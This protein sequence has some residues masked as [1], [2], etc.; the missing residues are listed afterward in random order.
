LQIENILQVLALA[1]QIPAS[2]VV[3]P[4]LEPVV[5]F[6]MGSRGEL[7]QVEAAVAVRHT[8][9]PPP[10]QH[11]MLVEDQQ[12]EDH[13]QITQPHQLQ[14]FIIHLQMLELDIAIWAAMAGVTTAAVAVVQ[15]KL[16]LTKLTTGLAAVMA[17]MA[18]HG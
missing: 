9:A 18:K 11:I 7:E 14:T 2:G 12:V 16:A 5:S 3:P 8:Q 13:A 6:M 10:A 4:M 15:A 1:V 17:V